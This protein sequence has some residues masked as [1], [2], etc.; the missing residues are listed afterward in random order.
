MRILPVLFAV[1]ALAGCHR[2]PDPAVLKAN[3][4]LGQ[5]FL[6][7]N[8]KAEGVRA[9]ASGLQYKVLK[10]GP[11]DGP[12]P[13]PADEIKIHYEGRLIDGKVFDSS[14]ERGVPAT[15]VL[16][17]LIPGWVEALQ[18]MRP[19]D[20][21]EIYVPAR[22]GYGE[23]EAGEIPPNSTLIFKIQLLGV[24]PDETSIQQG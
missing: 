8:A 15:F 21:W 11:A 14:L 22:L 16:G 2:G 5:A 9:T 23:R 17:N 4:E 20:E 10:S 12:R 7:Q 3:L 19:G 1:L 13:K 6:A 18:L 24:L